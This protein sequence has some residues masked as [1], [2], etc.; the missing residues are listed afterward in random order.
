MNEPTN[1]ASMENFE[2]AAIRDGKRLDF[3]FRRRGPVILDRLEP[4]SRHAVEIYTATAEAVLAGGATMPRDS[5]AG[6]G[7][8]GGAPSKEGR[9]A[10]VVDQVEFLRKMEAAVVAPPIVLSHKPLVAADP[11]H[12]WRRVC[13]ADVSM[14][15]YLKG[16]LGLARSAK[17]MEALQSA[18][19][20][21]ANRVSVAIGQTKSPWS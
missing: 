16:H 11:T 20:A 3:V 7:C 4:A 13:L 2:A 21:A 18:F 10:T 15:A 1:P 17:R 8:Q 9:Q 5:L 14:Q 19:I 12:L 6:S